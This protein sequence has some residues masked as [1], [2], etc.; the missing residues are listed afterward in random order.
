MRAFLLRRTAQAVVVVILV[1]IIVFVLIHL[2]PG[3]PARAMLGPR[4]DANE[5]RLFNIANGY[6]KSLPLQ[7]VTWIGQLLQF[8][9]GYSIH[10]NQTVAS[11]LVNN[12]GKSLVLVALSIIVALVVA[13][14]VGL[15]QATHRNRF[16]DHLLTTIS[17]VGYSMPV[18]WL[19]L[20]LILFF[21]VDLKIF[22]TEAPQATSIGGVLGDPKALVL[23]VVTLAVVIFASFSLFVRSSAIDNLIQEYVRTARSKGASQRRILRKH[24]LRNSMLPVITQVGFNFPVILAG[25]VMTETV[26]NYPGMGLLFWTAATSHD[27]PVLLGFVM[28][29]SVVT[30]L[31][32]LVA[33]LLYAVADPRIR[34]S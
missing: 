21:A 17:F 4:A 20:L 22:S 6:D 5:I 25:A 10:Y 8:N 32:S 26:F 2:I 31:C 34:L 33:D 7:Y 14:P 9:L 15:F 13:I 28:A 19:G 1:S 30:V 23:P 29:I 3:G 12:I 18:F 16:S 11:L 27:Y 24:V